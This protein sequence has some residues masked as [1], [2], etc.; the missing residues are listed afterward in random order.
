MQLPRHLRHVRAAHQRAAGR[1]RDRRPPRRG[2]PGDEVRHQARRGGRPADR[3]GRRQPRVRAQRLRRV[4]GASA[5]PT[6]STSTTSTAWTRTR[7]SR[8]PSARWPSS[9]RRA[10]SATSACRRRA[11]RR[12]AARTPCTRSRRCRPSTR[13]GRGTS[14]RRSCRR[15]EE[16]GIALVAY[17]PLGPRL[18]LRALQLAGGARRGRLPPPRAAL[19]GREP[20]A[21]PRAR[22]ACARARRRRRASRPGSS[23]SPG[24]SAAGEH[25]VPIPGTKRVTY[26]EEN[27]AAADVQLEPEEAQRIA[28]AVPAA[29]R[30]ALRRGGDEDGRALSALRSVADRV[31]ADVAA[32]VELPVR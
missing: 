9:C 25:I 30:R 5:A 10:R 4:A 16:L 17:S 8:R 6:T 19:H 11:P 27:V 21:E 23:R 32:A 18:P 3:V 12:S 14:R 2:L 1:R 28:D 24:C 31:E 22:R 7:R 20:A 13:C 29:S 15:C 26:L